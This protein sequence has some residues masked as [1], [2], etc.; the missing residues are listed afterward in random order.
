MSGKLTSR[1]RNLVVGLLSLVV[2]ILLGGLLEGGLRL[3]QWIRHGTT[4]TSVFSFTTNSAT[5]QRIPTP[6]STT[7]R[8]SI[9]SL[10]FRS[11]EIEIPKP[12]SRIRLAFVGASTTFCA[13]ATRNETTWPHLVWR[14]LQTTHSDIRF[15]YVNAGVPGYGI[16]HSLVDLEH[17]VKP[18]APDVIIIYHGANDLSYDTRQLA[19]QQGIVI[20][21]RDSQSWSLAWFLIRKNLQVLARQ[22][23][24]VSGKNRLV[25]NPSE[26]SQ[27]FRQE[28]TK[29]ILASK[30]LA[31]VVAVATHSHKF[32]R[33][34]SRDE[35]LRVANTALY[36][37]PY[38]TLEGLLD[39]YDEY[40]RVI[41]EVAKESGVILIDAEFSIPGD[42]AHFNDSVHFTDA[43]SDAM[44]RAVVETVVQSQAL[45]ELVR[46][47]R[48]SQ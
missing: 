2:L 28:I 36:Y 47:G 32:R 25:F 39:A 40:N 8:I 17:R 10:G 26:I 4:T 41:R 12:K 23:A 34:Q 33:G 42:D 30:K 19:E 37:M 43:G 21:E 18:L 3:R 9:N 38:M 7:S 1:R 20:P 11:P 31:P 22:H 45:R 6:G 16:S 5:G 14:E 13:E 44:A 15:D 29:L 48:V 27:G 46:S 24:A 35:L